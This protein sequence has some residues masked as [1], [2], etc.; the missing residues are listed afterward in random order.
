MRGDRIQRDAEVLILE[1]QFFRSFLGRRTEVSQGT[2]GAWG[3]IYDVLVEPV[4][5]FGR[6]CLLTR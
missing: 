5:S 6:V 1:N 3:G 2:T 4:D